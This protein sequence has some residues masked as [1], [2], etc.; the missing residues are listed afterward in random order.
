M[1]RQEKSPKPLG[2]VASSFFGVR[3]LDA[4]LDFWSTASIAALVFSFGFRDTPKK[5]DATVS[6]GL[7]VFSPL[8]RFAKGEKGTFW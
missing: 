8:I 3:R 2:T 7:A 1:S 4:A 5:D 6:N